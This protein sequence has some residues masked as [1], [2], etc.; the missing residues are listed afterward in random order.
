[1]CNSRRSLLEV[2]ITWRLVLHG[3]C[4]LICALMRINPF[5][6][7]LLKGNYGYYQVIF[8]TALFVFSLKL[9]P[10]KVHSWNAHGKDSN[11]KG[12]RLASS[13]VIGYVSGLLA[14]FLLPISR[15]GGYRQIFTL[16]D[17]GFAF[18]ISPL[19][20]LSWLVAFLF[21]LLI[22]LLTPPRP[23]A[24]MGSPE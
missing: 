21:G 16:N 6:H 7:S 19:I 3:L 15:Q 9:F 24:H 22:V 4:Y 20:S 23:R 18:F 10:L 12:F 5:V 17:I 1:M 11:R 13:A 8:Y 14:F 2:K